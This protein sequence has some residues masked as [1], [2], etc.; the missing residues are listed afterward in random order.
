MK[1]SFTPMR[2]DDRLELIKQGEVLTINGEAFDFSE[3]PEGATL[4][5]A[6]V[7]CDWLI[8]DVERIGGQITL[9]L[10]L[11]HGARAPAET[12]FPDPVTVT[13][14]PVALPPYE[15]TQAPAE[16]EDEA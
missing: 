14:G 15:T 9:T 8:S 5:R 4:P 13:D 6:A 11:P 16:E 3:V 2:R 12:L 7:V 10:I 1:I